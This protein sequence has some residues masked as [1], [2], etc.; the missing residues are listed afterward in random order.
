MITE[1]I[2]YGRGIRA[3]IHG[4]YFY[5][6]QIYRIEDEYDECDLEKGINTN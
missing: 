5:N 4:P 2:P 1:F 6:D 3:A